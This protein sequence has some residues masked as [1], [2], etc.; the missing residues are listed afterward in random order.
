MAIPN[1]TNIIGYSKAPN[2]ATRT[3]KTKRRINS[4][5]STFY[6]VTKGYK[7]DHFEAWKINWK[8]KAKHYMLMIRSCFC[9]KN[10][11]DKFSR[12]GQIVLNRL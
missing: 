3:S 1:N 6:R 8:S 10:P 11:T 12:K 5:P 7:N 4:I 9:D 2:E